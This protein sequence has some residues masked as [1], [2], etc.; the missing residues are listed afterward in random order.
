MTANEC[1]NEQ[2]PDV[3]VCERGCGFRTHAKYRMQIHTMTRACVNHPLIP[4]A[5]R[6]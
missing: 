1:P 2:M 4:K 5:D 6:R 3:L